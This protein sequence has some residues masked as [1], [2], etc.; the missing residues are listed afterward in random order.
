MNCSPVSV[1]MAAVVISSFLTQIGSSRDCVCELINSEETFPTE[2]LKSIQVAATR[3][4]YSINSAKMFEVDALLLGLHHR[5]VHLQENMALLE[6][7]DDGGLYG[8]VS[9]RIIENELVE[10][11]ELVAKLNGTNQNHQRLSGETSAQLRHMS[12][13]LKELEK[14]DHGHVA[15]KLEENKRL[16]RSLIQCQEQLHATPPPPTQPTEKCPQGHLVK[17]EGPRVYTATQYGTSYPYGSWGRDPV[18]VAGKEKLFW[19]VALTS[20]NV[21]ANYVRMYSGLSALIAGSN[22]GDVTIAP[23]NPT[24]N[25]IHGP[26]VVLYNNTLYYGCYNTPSVCSFNMT[27]RTVTSVALPKNSGF[28][29]KFPFCHLEACYPHTDLD[30]ATDES[31]VW[32]MYTSPENYGN[33]I[34]NKVIPGAPPSLGQAWLTS[35]HKRTATNTFM[36]CGVL[37]AT[38]YVDKETEEI[39]YSFDTET[40]LENYNVNIHLKKMH[41]NIQSLNYDPTDRKLYVYSDAYVLTYDTIF[42]NF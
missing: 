12:T 18:P 36:V 28:N 4:N 15:T 27:D 29:N 37:Y 35:L 9:L 2:K 26:N 5:L 7:E 22:M 31:G 30:L 10:I 3:S 6:S 25:T 19:L 20:S 16:K 33:V 14:F 1:W 17:V 32:V 11:L 38:R 40:G 23:S 41:P 24:T 13:V 39:F 8:A 34:I 42:K 21:F